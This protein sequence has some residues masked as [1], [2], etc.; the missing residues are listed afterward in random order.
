MR[1]P[2]PPAV[3]RR[4]PSHAARGIAPPRGG[5]R[6]PAAPQ[7]LGRRLPRWPV[8]LAAV[9]LALITVT[10]VRAAAEEPVRLLIVA[11]NVE[12]ERA[13]AIRAG[14][15]ATLSPPASARP[16]VD[17]RLVATADLAAASGIAD[18]ETGMTPLRP[19]I[20]MLDPAGFGSA[21]V[22]R[23]E[24][25]AVPVIAVDVALEFPRPA[26]FIGVNNRDLGRKLAEALH[27]F[28]PEGGTY[29]VITD[30]LDNA[31][32]QERL[33]GLLDGLRPVWTASA[34]PV[35]AAGADPEPAASR[36][37]DLLKPQS[38]PLPTAI[39]SL[40][41]WPMLAPG[42]WAEMVAA[43]RGR[44]ERRETLLI[45]ADATALQV[46]QLREG[47]AHALV[48]VDAASLGT[49]AARVARKLARGEPVPRITYVAIDI[50]TRD[51]V[52]SR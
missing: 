42:R 25:L 3:D 34:P 47:Q 5:F 40:G 39:V 24:R 31:I 26:A 6:P 50:L 11:P 15:E 51:K 45:A 17:C 13:V 43:N 37:A 21:M 9:A 49:A 28:R 4:D 41:A 7:G 10:P 2:L 27:R 20:A 33:G 52:R 14:C 19:V 1:Q 46:T 8:S 30:S 38:A 35:L 29:A 32:A 16:A 44:I 48:A 23:L 22:E 18:G 12:T 36:V